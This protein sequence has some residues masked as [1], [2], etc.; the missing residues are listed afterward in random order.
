MG[1]SSVAVTGVYAKA[2]PQESINE[3]WKAVG[4]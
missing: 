3:Y 1:H 2:N 4:V